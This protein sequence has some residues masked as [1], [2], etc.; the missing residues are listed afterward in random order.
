[1]KGDDCYLAHREDGAGQ[2]QTPLSM[3]G[4]GIA[5]VVHARARD[6]HQDRRLAIIGIIAGVLRVMVV[7]DNDAGAIGRH[8][9]CC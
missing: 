1:M 8:C 3:L 6:S 5:T 9:G 7:I 4:L 2:G